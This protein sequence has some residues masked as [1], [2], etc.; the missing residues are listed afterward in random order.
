MVS[1]G[2]YNRQNEDKSIM[3][4]AAQ[5]QLY[6]NAK[7]NNT[8]YIFFS[9]AVPLSLSIFSE[10]FSEKIISLQYLLSI[11]VVFLSLYI[12][13]NIEDSKKLAAFIQQK[14]DIYVYKMAWNERIFGKNRDINNEIVIYSKKILKNLDEKQKLNNWY[15]PISNAKS[16]TECV[17]SCQKENYYWDVGLRKRFKLV[18]IVLSAILIII[19][20]V[21]GIFNNE[22]INDLFSKLFLIFPVLIWLWKTVKILDKDIETLKELDKEFNKTN[23]KTLSDLEDIQNIIFK[24]RQNCYLIP[25]CIYNF[26]KNNDEDIAHRRANIL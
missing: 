19:I 10:Y 9:L 14:F 1:R 15:T 5:R 22:S 16:L 18:S 21:I 11:V 24:H 3:L 12:E 25:E 23:K 2:I 20:A 7:K 17:L 4:L 6:R 8:Y 13:K 26:F